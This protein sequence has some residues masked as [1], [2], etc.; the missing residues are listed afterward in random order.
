[1]EEIVQ[2][3]EQLTEVV[4][5]SMVPMWITIIGAFG[6]ILVSLL[7]VWQSHRQNKKNVELQKQ[8]EDNNALLQKKLS[9]R[10]EK[11]QMRGDF[12]K[13]YDAFCLAQNI[14]AA[15][16]NNVHVFFS[17]F[18]ILSNM[19][20]H[21]I[22]EINQATN[23]MCQAINRAKLLLPPSDTELRRV[24]EEV[25]STC[26]EVENKANDYYYSG[27]AIAASESAWRTISPS[28]S[29]SMYDYNALL[30]NPPAYENYLK[31]CVND[32][33]KELECLIERAISYF[34]YEKFDKY[35]EP[36]LQIAPMEVSVD[37]TKSR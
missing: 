12:L 24:L 17:N 6:P 10:D 15:A 13:I 14:L 16:S 2:K 31:L 30:G 21:W 37:I 5:R 4:G 18:S 26:K 33:T 35:F 1:M 20:L 23:A 3:I 27:Q 19:P 29:V 7:V 11:S 36:Y 25:F 28:W 34:P 8:I 22:N 9:E 32:K